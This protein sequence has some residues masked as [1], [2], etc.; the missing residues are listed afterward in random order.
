MVQS[1]TS[2]L[3]RRTRARG[4]LGRTAGRRGPQRQRCDHVACAEHRPGVVELHADAETP[5]GPPRARLARG[6]PARS[7]HAHCELCAT[8][9][10]VT[11]HHPPI[12]SAHAPPFAL[13]PAAQTTS[14]FACALFL[15]APKGLAATLRHHLIPPRPASD[16]LLRHHRSF[17]CARS[18]P[19]A[20]ARP[21]RLARAHCSS[22]LRSLRAS[23]SPVQRRPTIRT[24]TWSGPSRSSRWKATYPKE[25]LLAGKEGTATIVLVTIDAD[26]KVTATEIAESAGDAGLDDAALAAAAKW[27][28][29][30]ARRDG[31]AI[32]S[33]VHVPF[34]FHAHVA[35]SP[36]PSPSP[37]V[38][39]PVPVPI[40]APV[41]SPRPRPR[42]LCPRIN[43]SASMVPP[44]SRRPRR[45][46]LRPRQSTAPTSRA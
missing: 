5:V 27:R 26:G 31:R 13:P 34:H 14:R 25:A 32:E 21:V 28:F 37:S 24:R 8:S 3:S 46:R 45:R 22:S 10:A 40:S 19:I 33:Q 38:P 2:R 44:A 30:P 39:V 41:S 1:R 23:C 18:I 17:L 11:H 42:P 16:A 7:H 43:R 36:S 35:P 6:A 15:L 4:L 9:S 20:R 29:R 12:A